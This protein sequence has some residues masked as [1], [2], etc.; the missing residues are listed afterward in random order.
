M[1]RIRSSKIGSR[2]CVGKTAAFVVTDDRLEKFP[3]T[4][5]YILGIVPIA[6]NAWVGG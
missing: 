4:K 3:P 5:M 6:V 1:K 2:V